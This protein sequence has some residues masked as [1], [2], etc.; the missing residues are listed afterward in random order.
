MEITRKEFD[1]IRNL[2]TLDIQT[3]D[4]CH[5]LNIL[6]LGWKPFGKF[7]C[8]LHQAEY[9]V[10]WE[11]CYKVCLNIWGCQ[12]Y[13]EV[14]P[15]RPDERPPIKPNRPYDWANCYLCGKELRGAGKTGK[16]KNRN[17]PRFWGLNT[18]YGI[19]CLRCV[20]KKYYQKLAKSKRRT[21]NKYVKR[22]YV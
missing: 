2:K 4:F 14:E 16:I 8:R 11:L 7:Y 18:E 1:R 13:R 5:R 10:C 6:N 17:N 15:A 9:I 12:L 20:G 3:C 21:F 19:L 22:G